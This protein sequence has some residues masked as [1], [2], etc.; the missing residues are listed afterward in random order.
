MKEVLSSL[1]PIKVL[2]ISNNTVEKKLFTKLYKSKV[3]ISKMKRRERG[4]SGIQKRG[5]GVAH[6][7]FGKGA[8][9]AG[10]WILKYTSRIIKN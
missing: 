3:D 7:M 6:D 1:H 2:W 5:S 4:A 10:L 8:C 9:K